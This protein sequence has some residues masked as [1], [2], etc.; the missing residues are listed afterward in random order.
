[1]KECMR[2]VGKFCSIG[3]GLRAIDEGR[4]AGAGR[5]L[6]GINLI[7]VGLWKQYISQ[8]WCVSPYG[9]YCPHS[10]NFPLSFSW[11]QSRRTA[12]SPCPRPFRSMVG[13]VALLGHHR[14]CARLVQGAQRGAEVVA[15]ATVEDGSR[16]DTLQLPGVFRHEE[17]RN[18]ALQSLPY[19]FY[20]WRVTRKEQSPPPKAAGPAVHEPKAVTTTKCLSAKAP[21]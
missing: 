1:M 5:Y 12:L 16:S 4:V 14:Q 15:V 19:S 11:S 3:S 20:G 2:R 9:C 17:L 8:L 6:L 7:V 21:W 10:C 18:A 13:W